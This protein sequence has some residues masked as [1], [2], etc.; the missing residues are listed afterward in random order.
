MVP[1][2]Q[3][4]QRP[5][6]TRVHPTGDKTPGGEGEGR[7]ALQGDPTGVPQGPEDYTEHRVPGR[8][9]LQTEERD[10]KALHTAQHDH[11]RLPARRHNSLHPV[12]VQPRDEVSPARPRVQVRQPG[13]CYVAEEPAADA[14]RAAG[15]PEEVRRDREQAQAPEGGEEGGEQHWQRHGNVHEGEREQ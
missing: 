13:D 3:R 7:G 2:R 10:D 4:I 9:E 12:A 8:E 1:G 15:E 6:R 5:K 11:V 14:D